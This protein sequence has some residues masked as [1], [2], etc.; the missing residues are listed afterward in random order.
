MIRAKDSSGI[1]F[2]HCLKQ[3]LKRYSGRPD[4]NNRWG[5]AQIFVVLNLLFVG[6]ITNKSEVS[7][8]I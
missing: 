7:I 8:N 5:C 6:V 1:L 3:C 4:P 2:K